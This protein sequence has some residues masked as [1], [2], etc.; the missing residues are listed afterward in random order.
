MPAKK[1]PAKAP[2]LRVPKGATLKQIYAIIKKKF[3]AADLAWYC[4]IDESQMVSAEGLVP[5]LEA[6][7]KE[8][9]VKKKAAGKK[10]KTGK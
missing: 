6:I 10:K 7:H 8:V 9:M 3:T 2:T 1:K 5:A 4:N